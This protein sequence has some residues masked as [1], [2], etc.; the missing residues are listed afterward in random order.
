MLKKKEQNN[1]ILHCEDEAP[2][3]S[4]I[5][6]DSIESFNNKKIKTEIKNDSDSVI[7]ND[8]I[9]SEE[10]DIKQVKN[11]YLEGEKLRTRMNNLLD[12]TDFFNDYS[13]QKEAEI[14]KNLIIKFLI[15]KYV[16]SSSELKKYN[17][18]DKIV[19]YIQNLLKS[20][21]QPKK[22]DEIY[23][24][25]IINNL[26]VIKIYEM[27]INE[28]LLEAIPKTNDNDQDHRRP[29]G[30]HIEKNRGIV[31]ARKRKL[32]NPRMKYR[33]KYVKKL[34]KHNANVKPHVVE[35]KKYGGEQHGIRKNII[36]SVKLN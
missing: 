24:A 13:Y 2:F 34:K 20:L 4:D 21:N 7:S 28:K 9:E 17:E 5:S 6:D 27:E 33:S 32:K 11:E 15:F 22:F 19:G 36:H 18:K 14:D 29:I 1:K 10:V 25:K 12:E 31:R 30:N 3:E 23:F 35:M 16:L 8:S 26:K